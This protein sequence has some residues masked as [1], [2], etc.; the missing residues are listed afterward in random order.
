MNDKIIQRLRPELKSLS[1]YKVA[2]SDGFVKLDAM[3][4]PY[5]W[6]DQL[7]QQWCEYLSHAAINRYPDPDPE[8]LKNSLQHQFGPTHKDIQ[9]LLGNG[10]DELIQLLVLAIARPHASVLTVS[11]SFSM[12]QII[13]EMLGVP[14]HSIA[15]DENHELD[16]AMM[17]AAIEQHDP[18]LLF[19]A[20]PNN[21]TGNLWSRADVEKIIQT[22]QGIVVID[23]AY[24][25][26]ASD[27]FVDDLKQYPHVLLLRT[28]SKLGL[29]G[30]RFGWLAGH[31]ELI[32]ELNKLRLPYNINLLT[33]LTM[34]FALDNYSVLAQQAATLCKSRAI[35]ADTLAAI[36]NVH[37]YPSEANFLLFKVYNASANEIFNKLLASKILIKNVSHQPGL[38]DCLRVTVGTETENQAFV[39]ALTAALG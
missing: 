35:L 36:P 25:P 28:A 19:L 12:Y 16:L 31:A 22:S 39:N 6:S 18:A 15:L 21:P 20:Y 3:E 33:Q 37:V 24:G 8:P 5:Q 32:M 23:E 13:S 38:A 29:A 11:P 30:L 10:S 27:S 17:L 9:F 4:N 7:N 2:S 14:C 34:Q 26:F 1:A